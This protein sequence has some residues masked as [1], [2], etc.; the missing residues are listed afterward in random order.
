MYHDKQHVNS[1]LGFKE[2]RNS[3]TVFLWCFFDGK[4]NLFNEPKTAPICSP[5]SSVVTFQKFSLCSATSCSQIW[6]STSSRH[7]TRSESNKQT[8]R[9]TK[10]SC[11]TSPVKS[12]EAKREQQSTLQTGRGQCA[13][14]WRS[15]WAQCGRV[16]GGS[17]ALSE[18]G[19]TDKN[20]PEVIIQ[21]RG[22]CGFVCC[23]SPVI[24]SEATCWRIT[25]FSSVSK[26]R[27]FLPIQNSRLV[28]T[29]GEIVCC[30]SSEP[31][32]P[33]PDSSWYL[34]FMRQKRPSLHRTDWSQP[35]GFFL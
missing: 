33:T 4:L 27:I 5:S 28:Q 10:T 16:S 17:S 32:L 25:D 35:F 7:K 11:N 12:N 15:C 26:E 19:R 3:L 14:G 18:T 20:T 1:H 13:Q 2:G 24:R 21:A 6:F 9:K 8:R 23:C 30:R 29:N 22:S 31:L 34:L